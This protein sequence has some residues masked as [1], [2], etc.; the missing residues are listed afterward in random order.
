MQGRKAPLHSGQVQV[1]LIQY[2]NNSD[3][4]RSLP[5]AQTLLYTLLLN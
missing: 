3:S 2:P 5:A 1:N 4:P